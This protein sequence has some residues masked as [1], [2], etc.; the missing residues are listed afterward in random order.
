MGEGDERSR[1]GV[2]VFYN[3]ANFKINVYSNSNIFLKVVTFT[4][5]SLYILAILSIK[6]THKFKE[7]EF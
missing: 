7:A 3:F 5:P 4:K 6:I 1:V 2:N